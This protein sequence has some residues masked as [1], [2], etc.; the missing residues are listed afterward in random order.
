MIAA[1]DVNA[2]WPDHI[3]TAHYSVIYCECGGE[4]RA[5]FG[6]GVRAEFLWAQHVAEA[7]SEVTG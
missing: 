5:E 7:L 4:F 6:N 3:V 1:K 2:H